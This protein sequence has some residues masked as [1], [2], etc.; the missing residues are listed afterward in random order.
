MLR[1]QSQPNPDAY[2]SGRRRTLRFGFT[3]LEVLVVVSII[4]LL[5]SILLPVMTG[6]RNEATTA[7]CLANLREISAASSQYMENDEQRQVVWYYYPVNRDFSGSVQTCT[8]WV[9]GGFKAPNP[10]PSD[11]NVDSSLYPAQLRPLNGI[12]APHVQGSL[13]WSIRG[14]DIIDIYICPADR[15]N[16]TS[17]ISEDITDVEEES[18]SSWEANGSS[19]T[20]NTRW[21][22]G[23]SHDNGGNFTLE[24]FRVGRAPDNIPFGKKLS[25]HLIGD[26][27]A[28]FIMWVEQGF[29]SATYRAWPTLPNGAAPKRRGW[30]RKFSYWCVGF[31]DGHALYGH[32]DTRLT[33]GGLSGTIWQPNFSP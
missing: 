16:S 13:A 26:G 28:R 11:G 6:A 2:H 25:P 20:L 24:D 9:F 5:I 7:K 33:G 4:A 21:A 19:Y 8:P 30:H 18:R 3:L 12:L 15:T 1:T 31:A 23:Y 29:Y 27:A 10:D 17:I 22:Q 14:N 32:Y